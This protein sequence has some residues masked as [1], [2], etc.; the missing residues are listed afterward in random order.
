MLYIFVMPLS[1]LEAKGEE[2]INKKLI[3]IIF[4]VFIFSVFLFSNSKEEKLEKNEVTI[5]Y[6]S[7]EMN[8]DGFFREQWGKA[9]RLNINKDFQIV[10][11]KENWR[12]GEDLGGVIYLMT[13]K[14]N[15][16]VFAK[17]KDDYPRVNP[18]LDEYLWNGDGVE[19]YL[20]NLSSGNL[21]IMCLAAN[22]IIWLWTNKL[23]KQE[24]T[25]MYDGEIK[26]VQTED[27]YNLEARIPFAYFDN[28][29]M[30]RV[31]GLD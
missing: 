15:L 25:L 3:Y 28:F 24:H 21:A 17:I 27:G 9:T 4:I 23:G 10:D 14:K 22:D 11:G 2:T 20:Q 30:K 29:K 26:T 5:P 13:D 8:I 16:Y 12:D 18:Q 1:Y 31:K 19:I 6:I 7:G